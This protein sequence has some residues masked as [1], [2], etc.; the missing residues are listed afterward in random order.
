MEPNKARSLTWLC[1]GEAAQQLYTLYKHLGEARKQMNTEEGRVITE[2]VIRDMWKDRIH[3]FIVFVN[4][5][6][7]MLQRTV[8]A[9]DP[10]LHEYFAWLQLRLI[11]EMT[12]D[13]FSKT[14]A[15]MVQL[16]NLDRNLRFLV[17]VLSCPRR[18]KRSFR[19]V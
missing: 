7:P 3:P 10:K 18:C 5:S 9:Q 4:E 12:P 19:P 1:D 8:V 13:E 15:E 14:V 6:L 17:W 16:P 11:P 2:E